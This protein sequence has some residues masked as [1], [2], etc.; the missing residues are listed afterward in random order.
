MRIAIRARRFAPGPGILSISGTGSLDH[1]LGVPRRSSMARTLPATR[2]HLVCSRGVNGTMRKTSPGKKTAFARD[3]VTTPR[4]H[5]QSC[6]CQAAVA[7]AWQTKCEHVLNFT[8]HTYLNA[9]PEKSAYGGHNMIPLVIISLFSGRRSPFS[10][11][12]F[13][14][15]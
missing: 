9:S 13:R 2:C 12:P 5:K 8:A 7:Q 1:W 3:W 14:S 15:P 10:V 6:R 11:R 4:R